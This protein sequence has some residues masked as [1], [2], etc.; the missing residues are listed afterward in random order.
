M[1]EYLQMSVR[2][3]TEVRA[4]EADD[5][6]KFVAVVLEDRTTG[7]STRHPASVSGRGSTKKLACTVGEGAAAAIQIRYHLDAVASSRMS[8]GRKG[9]R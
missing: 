1:L 9:G 7:A 5:N 6:G 4:F 8:A 3:S 2:Y